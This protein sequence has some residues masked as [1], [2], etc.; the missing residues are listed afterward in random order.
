M[1]ITAGGLILGLAVGLAAKELK[2]ADDR[3]QIRRRTLEGPIVL[4]LAQMSRNAGVTNGHVL[5]ME[6]TVNG[7]NLNI[8]IKVVEVVL[9]IGTGPVTIQLLTMVAGDVLLWDPLLSFALVT[10]SHALSMA[11]TRNGLLGHLA[12]N[13]VGEEVDLE[14]EL[15]TILTQNMVAGIAHILEADSS[16]PTA[17]LDIARLT[18][19][20][21]RGPSLVRVQGRV[22]LV[23]GKELESVQTQGRLIAAATAPG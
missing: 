6:G 5:F 15:A 10:Q 4:N 11:T 9:C 19:A 3:A 13:P 22:E 2:F 12:L 16:L 20:T 17:M 1:G 23:P 7:L 8:V 14:L 21:C 18:G